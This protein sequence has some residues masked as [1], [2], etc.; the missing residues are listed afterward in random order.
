MGTKLAPSY[1]NIFIGEFEETHV[2]TYQHRPHW[3]QSRDRL[4]RFINH[5][6]SCHHSIKFTATISPTS[7][8]F[9]DTTL[10]KATD[11]SLTTDL[12]TKPT[13]SH[14]YL[15]YSSCHPG[16][17]KK[18]LPLSQFLQLKRIR[19][20]EEDFEH[21][22]STMLRHF[23][24]RGYPHSLLNDAFKKAKN[25]PRDLLLNP[26][27]NTAQQEKKLFPV[28]TFHPC[29]N[30][31][32]YTIMTNWHLLDRSCST[33][34][35][36]DH[37]LIFGHRRNKNLK[38]LLVHA[39]VNYHYEKPDIPHHH[40]CDRENTCKDKKC[41]YCPLLDKTGK[42][43]SHISHEKFTARKNI[44]CKSHNVIYCITCQQC[45]IQYVGQSKRRLMDRLQGHFYN[46]SKKI[47]QIG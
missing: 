41:R 1:A 8:C 31:L 15:H 21:H 2:Y 46:V 36:T 14:S 9:L 33:R 26:T 25:T 47:E 24:N 23:L 19:S 4:D 16:H 43:A 13:D 27:K 29:G 40:L 38:D 12:Y 35:L 11:G 34:G 39:K 17:I 6:N 30:I 22:S 42:I 37:R 20:K 3:W 44:T 18:S 5:L 32:K 28:S 10:N 45:G 7:V